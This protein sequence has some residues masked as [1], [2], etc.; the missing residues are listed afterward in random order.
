M[1]VSAIHSIQ[2]DARHL[3]LG[4]LAV[5]NRDVLK[6]ADRFRPQL[7]RIGPARKFALAGH[8]VTAL[9]SRAGRFDHQRIVSTNH[10]AVPHPDIFTGIKVDPVVVGHP[11]SPGANSHPVNQHPFGL[12]EIQC[13]CPRIDEMNISHTNTAESFFALFKRGHYGT[14]HNLSKKHMHRYCDEF[15]FRWNGRKL[16]DSERR[17]LAVVGIEGKRLYL[18]QPLGEA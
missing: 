5:R 3:C 18:Y 15:S 14:F 6:P 8:D 13:P 1:Q 9:P 2:S 12:E 16:S 4:D 7:D 17:D 11:Q 10:V